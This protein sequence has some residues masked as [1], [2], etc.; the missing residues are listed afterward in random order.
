MGKAMNDARTRR[1][2][3]VLASGEEEQLWT[4]ALASQ[5]I[6]GVVVVLD[7]DS[8]LATIGALVVD[9]PVLEDLDT[10]IVVLAGDLKQRHPHLQV[11]IRLPART[12]ISRGE[13]AWARGVGIGSLLPG[14][15]VAAW[16][17]SLA[18][19]L[20]RV[21]ESLGP[22]DFDEAALEHCTR[23]LVRKGEEPRPGPI[24]DS[25]VDAFRLEREGVSA[26]SVLALLQGPGGVEVSER[27][28]RGKTYADCFV[29]SEAIDR[30]EASLGLR[31]SLATAACAFLWRTGRIHHVLRRADFADDFLFFRFS[32]SREEFEH[33][34]LAEA[35]AALRTGVPVEDRT[36]L[37]KSYEACFVGSDAVQWLASRYRISRGAAETIGHRLLE[38][39]AFRHVLN[40]HGF[41]DG[42]LYYRFRA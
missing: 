22:V 40:E 12:G 35:A 7:G 17:E 23:E 3:L 37:A 4:L 36:Y 14:S 42:N 20:L 6:E 31:R 9:A 32:G 30:V 38:L 27:T 16:K 24:K 10:S 25:F 26:A 8:R 33:V 29:A 5:G 15:S 39:G 41:V 13:Q 2:G 11:F 28:F 34:D 21:L 18:P 19:V 1:V